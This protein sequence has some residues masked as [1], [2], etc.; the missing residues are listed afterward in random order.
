MNEYLNK[1]TIFDEKCM[2][3]S[4]HHV[5]CSHEDQER[6]FQLVKKHFK[7]AENFVF[8]SSFLH[9]FSALISAESARIEFYY[10]CR[11][12]GEKYY[13]CRFRKVESYRWAKSLK[14]EGKYEFK[15]FVKLFRKLFKTLEMLCKKLLNFIHSFFMEA[16]KCF[17]SFIWNLF[18]CG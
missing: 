1:K 16:L 12:N 7:R 10:S 15:L 9:N 4:T 5:L 18:S 14:T 3:I 2:T 13:F 6:I 17:Y 8:P 11:R